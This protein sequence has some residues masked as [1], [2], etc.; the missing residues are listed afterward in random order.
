MVT[1]TLPIPETLFEAT[2]FGIGL[3]FGRCFGKDLDYKIQQSEWFKRRDAF[4][5]WVVKFLLDF[6]HHWWIGALI[7]IYCPQYPEAYWFGLGLIV[8]DAP[9]IPNRIRKVF[10]WIFK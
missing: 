2:W 7:M 10:G 6:L 9:D 4:G 8:D 5:K 3:T 1:L